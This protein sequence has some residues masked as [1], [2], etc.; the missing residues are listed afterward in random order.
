M[1]ES[2]KSPDIEKLNGENYF[3]WIE[4]IECWLTDLDLWIDL[5]ENDGVLTAANTEKAAKAYRK[6]IL[7]CDASHTTIL[8]AEAK[9]NSVKL[10]RFLGVFRVY[11]HEYLGKIHYWF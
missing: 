1:S 3:S 8:A 4:H 11:S 6:I 5:D 2:C 10:L 7:K 9:N